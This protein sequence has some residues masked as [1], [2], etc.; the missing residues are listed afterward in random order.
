MRSVLSIDLLLFNC[1][2]ILGKQGKVKLLL[3]NGDIYTDFGGNKWSLNPLCLTSASQ[4]GGA[5][6]RKGKLFCCSVYVCVESIL[7]WSSQECIVHNLESTRYT[8][9]QVC[10]A[11]LNYIMAVGDCRPIQYK[12]NYVTPAWPLLCWNVN[13]ILVHCPKHS[14]SSRLTNSYLEFNVQHTKITAITVQP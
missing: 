7:R 4:S 1:L 5:E 6:E 9:I 3:P 14:N 11:I 12:L 8:K 13:V 2:K 10:T